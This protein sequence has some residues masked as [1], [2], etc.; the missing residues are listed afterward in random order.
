MAAKWIIQGDKFIKGHVD[1]HMELK[2]GTPHRVKGGGWFYI[3]KE[4]KT[5]FLYSASFDFG[6]C[7]KEEVLKGLQNYY[8]PKSWKGF[9]VKFTTRPTFDERSDE[10]I[11]E[12]K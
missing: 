4:S 5:L 11:L 12:I 10:T 2:N 1:L 8:W 9:K 3:D 7:T 6:Q